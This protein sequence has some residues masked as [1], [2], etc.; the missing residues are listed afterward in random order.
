MQW[1]LLIPSGKKYSQ[2]Y[3][4]IVKEERWYYSV[5][6]TNIFKY[7]FIPSLYSSMFS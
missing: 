2:R 3:W 6:V 4:R 7:M 5:S 1:G